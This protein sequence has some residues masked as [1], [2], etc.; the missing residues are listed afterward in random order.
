MRVQKFVLVLILIFSYYFSK[1]QNVK[2]FFYIEKETK[3]LPVYVRGNLDN[4]TILLFVQGG[5]GD[6][7]ID[8][9][10]SDYPRWKKT[11]EKKVA[12]AYYDQRGLNK[13]VRKIDSTKITY[14][15][16]SED[17]IQL[18]KKLKEKYDAKVYLMGHSF[19][20]GMVYHCLAKFNQ[21]T[22]LI[23]G[24]IILNSPITTDHT[25]IRYKHYRP[26]YLKNLAQEFI[27]KNIDKQKW[28]EAYDWIVEIDSITTR[29]EVIKWNTYV[30]SA[31]ESEN[32]KATVGMA[33]RVLF[34]RPY[35]PVKYLNFKDN[36]YVSKL[37]WQ[38]QKKIDF[39]EVLPK[40]N[41]SVLLVTGRFDD[42]AIPEEIRKAEELLK[43]SEAKVLQ[44]AGHQS[45][46]DQP[47]LFNQTILEFVLRN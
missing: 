21:L 16:Y 2:D 11:L 40:I 23:E 26:L 45:F 12:I 46:L 18:S 43:N 30:D 28:Q 25:P 37:I 44:N 15:Q 42:I 8:F 5:P 47:K 24:G 6:T 38:N 27:D 31:F 34:S 19:G 13:K 29:E 10:R 3:E 1:A 9:G 7:S 36:S 33:L 17:L 35:N 39:F 32:R 22:D 4:K 14:D 20:G 41:H